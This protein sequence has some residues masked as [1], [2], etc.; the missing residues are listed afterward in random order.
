M[1]D[2][3]IFEEYIED[4]PFMGHRCNFLVPSFCVGPDVFAR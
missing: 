4:A 2:G 3:T 1:D